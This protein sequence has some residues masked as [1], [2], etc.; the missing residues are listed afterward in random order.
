MRLTPAIAAAVGLFL[1]A[2][3]GQAA[4]EPKIYAYPSSA[5]YCPT[6]LQ[7]I[8]IS[9]VICCG[10]PNQP[11]TYAEVKS[12]PVVRRHRVATPR[13]SARVPCPEGTKGC[14]YN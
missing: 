13:R 4:A 10:T 5:N 6:G 9:G 12:H 2:M 7:P 1:T 8:T 3:V 14:S 11:M